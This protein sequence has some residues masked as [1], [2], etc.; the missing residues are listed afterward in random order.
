[1]EFASPRRR[2]IRVGAWAAAL[3]T[4]AAV[5]LA[6][7]LWTS[8]HVTTTTAPV[9]TV[10]IGTLP[11]NPIDDPLAALL[12]APPAFDSDAEALELLTLLA[13]E[14]N[15]PSTL[16]AQLLAVLLDS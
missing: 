3:A 6:V 5:L 14:Q 13:G 2:T 8:T 11:D 10:T 4:A 1:M 15:L 7:T 9:V 12:T 16:D